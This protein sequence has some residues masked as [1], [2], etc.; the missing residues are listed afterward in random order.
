MK[1]I[2]DNKDQT[3]LLKTPAYIKHLTRKDCANIFAIRARMIK[4]K[5]N[6]RNAHENTLCRWCKEKEE[7][8]EHI[9]TECPKFKKITK[10]LNYQK[11]MTDLVNL[12]KKESKMI[13]KKIMDIPRVYQNAFYCITV[14][15]A[16]Y[17]S[18]YVCQMPYCNC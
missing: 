11:I 8:Q 3:N 16:I 1:H 18:I 14:R 2:V 6:Y 4:V 10:N 7:P 5:T 12:L 17:N 15:L 13:E 9:L